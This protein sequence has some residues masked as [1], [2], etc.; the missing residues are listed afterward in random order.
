M[1]YNKFVTLRASWLAINYSLAAV[2]ELLSVANTS[3]LGLPLQVSTQIMQRKAIYLQ[4]QL[5]EMFKLSN[6]QL[7]HYFRHRL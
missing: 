7:T 2:P 4:K 6:A 1:K 3:K 5:I